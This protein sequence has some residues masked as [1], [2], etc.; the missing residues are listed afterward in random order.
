MNA[1]G[2]DAH[3]LLPYNCHKIADYVY[4][5]DFHGKFEVSDEIPGFH[6]DIVWHLR[7][8]IVISM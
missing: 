2:E 7:D 4:L 5:A 3:A 8:Y 6:I 1:V